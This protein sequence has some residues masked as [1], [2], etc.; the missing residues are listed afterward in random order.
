ME[1]VHQ[2]NLV[3]VHGR[4]HHAPRRLHLCRC[5]GQW[6]CMDGRVIG[7]AASVCEALIAWAMR[8]ADRVNEF[9][10]AAWAAKQ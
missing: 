2:A 3:W 5:D 6:H 7:S 10:L 9:N 4:W 8:A 1:I